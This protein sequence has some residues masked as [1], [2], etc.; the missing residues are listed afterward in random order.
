MSA[1]PAQKMV[2]MSLSLCRAL[3]TSRD[4]ASGFVKFARAG[5]LLIPASLSSGWICSSDNFSSKMGW[6]AILTA[7]SSERPIRELAER[8]Q[9]RT[10]D[11][12]SL[13][14]FTIANP[15]VRW[16]HVD[17]RPA[18]WYNHGDFAGGC[19][20]TALDMVAYYRARLPK[21]LGRTNYPDPGQLP[22][23]T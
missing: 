21:S 2:K 11:I 14:A 12:V 9:N 3:D 19:Q 6:V 23:E 13:L 17:H 5:P 20:L 8:I 4:G 22:I 10:G 7:T 16:G 18:S 15:F 1:K